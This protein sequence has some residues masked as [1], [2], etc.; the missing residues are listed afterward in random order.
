LKNF[1][2]KFR[3]LIWSWEFDILKI[4]P[5][6]FLFISFLPILPYEKKEGKLTSVL[7]KEASVENFY[8]LGIKSLG[9]LDVIDTG[10]K[11][12]IPKKGEAFYELY[13]LYEQPMPSTIGQKKFLQNNGYEKQ[14]IDCIV[15]RDFFL[16]IF[17]SDSE[18]RYL[19]DNYPTS[20]VPVIWLVRLIIKE[21]VSQNIYSYARFKNINTLIDK[22]SEYGDRFM[23]PGYFQDKFDY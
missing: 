12:Y 20:P 7:G 8:D 1:L 3:F 13:K 21:V 5:Y 23:P 11:I 16:Y 15:L 19:L 6:L 17:F 10:K 4:F 14:L 9:S 18:F 22:C 2:S